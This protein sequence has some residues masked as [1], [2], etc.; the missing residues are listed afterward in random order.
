[1]ELN[2]LIRNQIS[3]SNIIGHLYNKFIDSYVRVVFL[4]IYE[5]IK[6]NS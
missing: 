4:K 6:T 3:I 5:A 2:V 1:M